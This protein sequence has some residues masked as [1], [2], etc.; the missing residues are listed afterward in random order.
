L[1]VVV[2]VVVM[3]PLGPVVVEVEDRLAGG[4]PGWVR[5]EGLECWG[6]RVERTELRRSARASL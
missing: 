6:G 2:V 1:V 3:M 4:C 5:V